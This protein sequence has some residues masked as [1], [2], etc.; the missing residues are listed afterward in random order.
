MKIE[1]LL[2]VPDPGQIEKSVQL[3]QRY[4]CGFEY[5]DFY[6]PDFVEDDAR[7]KERIDLYFGMGNFTCMNTMH[8]AFYDVTVFSDD[9]RIVEVSDYR[10]EQS[11]RIACRLGVK[12]VVFHTNYVPNFQVDYYCQN[13]LERNVTYWKDK[14]EKYSD[15]NIYIENMFDMSPDLL[16][17]LAEKLSIYPNFGVCFDYAHAHAFGNEQEIEVWV[18][19]LAPYVKHIHINDNDFSHDLH[20]TIGEGKID[21]KL[22]K[23]FYETYF[24]QASVLVE[25]KDLSAAEQSLEF[26]RKL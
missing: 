8:G 23:K 6:V 17:Q 20:L 19:T 4:R 7:V 2:I 10:V 9:S 12:A 15:I 22:F 1:S 21:W 14:L 24:P 25:I 16:V 13:W 26:I 3:A 18:K 11:L 5:N